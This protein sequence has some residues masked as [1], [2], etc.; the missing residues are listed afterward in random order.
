MLRTGKRMAYLCAADMHSD[1]T[2]EVGRLSRQAAQYFVHV[3][4]RIALGL[5]GADRVLLHCRH[6]WL[7]IS[8]ARGGTVPYV[9]NLTCLPIS[10]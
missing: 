10:R 8:I 4:L 9:L 3:A 1:Q 6:P 5:P 7:G 2:V